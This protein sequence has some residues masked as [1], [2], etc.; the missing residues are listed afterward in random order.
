[1]VAR[2]STVHLAHFA[3][4][5]TQRGVAP[6]RERAA[7]RRRRRR[8]RSGRPC[9]A[10]FR[11]SAPSNR[12][13]CC[14]SGSVLPTLDRG[15]AARD[16][17]IAVLQALR[18]DDVTALAVDVAQQRDVRGAVRIVFDALDAR[19]N[20]VLVALEVDDAVVLLVTTTDVTGGDAAVV[21]T[22]A[23]LA[24]LLDA[25]PRAARPCAG[26]GVTTRTA[27]R[28]PGEVGLKVINAMG[29]SSGLGHHVDRLA[30]GQR[31]VRLAPVAAAA[32]AETEGLVLALDVHAR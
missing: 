10:S 29:L 19:R 28:R 9:R 25:A 14:V 30:F 2:H 4:A 18:G 21:V 17:L 27:L 26:P 8:G 5:Q 6:A 22:A 12:P 20:A 32:S 15:V 16:H 23:A 11:C 1:M 24:L 7:A 3:G 31:H 13:G